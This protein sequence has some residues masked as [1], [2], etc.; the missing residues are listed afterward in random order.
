MPNGYEME[1]RCGDNALHWKV[2]SRT[3]PEIE[4][5]V[6]LAAFNGIGACSCE[7][8]QIR[9]APEL[10]AGNRKGSRRCGHI[11]TA[12]NAFTDAMVQTLVRMH[13]ERAA[14]R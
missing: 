12:R 5:Q 10:R 1:A 13:A 4:H 14:T 11:L 2:T 9:I 7:H 8:F 6:D 3:R